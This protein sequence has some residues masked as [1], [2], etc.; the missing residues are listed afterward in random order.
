MEARWR[1][2]IWIHLNEYIEKA[3]QLDIILAASG[4]TVPRDGYEEFVKEL[5]KAMWAGMDKL[6]SV[7]VQIPRKYYSLVF[8]V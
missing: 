2:A 6:A 8:L 4:K 3:R 1:T 5:Y 7:L